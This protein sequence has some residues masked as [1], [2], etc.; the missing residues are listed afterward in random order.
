MTLTNRTAFICLAFVLCKCEEVVTWLNLTS[1][2]VKNVSGT[3][4]LNFFFSARA[5]KPQDVAKHESV[6]L[7]FSSLGDN[8]RRARLSLRHHVGSS[9][10]S[11]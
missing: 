1:H 6:Y 7:K 8:V 11:T 10:S 2:S 5:C 9:A 3:S 4:S